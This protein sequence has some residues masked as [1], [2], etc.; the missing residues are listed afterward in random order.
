M[1]VA[2][3]VLPDAWRHDT[4][5]L[6]APL[7]LALAYIVVRAVFLALQRGASR[8]LAQLGQGRAVVL[9]LVA[10]D[11]QQYQRR[12]HHRPARVCASIASL[13]RRYSPASQ[14]LARCR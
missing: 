13:A 2:A 10:H 5:S 11:G 3:L 4:Q 7:T 12:G 1:F 9:D 14:S 8:S 6:A